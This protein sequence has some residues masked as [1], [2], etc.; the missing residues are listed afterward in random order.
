MVAGAAPSK[1][2][3]RGLAEIAPV[4]LGLI[5]RQTVDEE[6]DG[7]GVPIAC[8]RG[9]A[10][11]PVVV[12]GSGRDARP[13]GEVVRLLGDVGN[14][15]AVADHR[16]AEAQQLFHGI[17]ESSS[18]RPFELNA[19]RRAVRGPEPQT[20]GEVVRHRARQAYRVVLAV[21]GVGAA[22]DPVR[23]HLRLLDPA[24]EA[25]PSV[26]RDQGN[27]FVEWKMGNQPRFRGLPGRFEFFG[28]DGVDEG[29]GRRACCLDELPPF[30]APALCLCFGLGG[31]EILGD[32]VAVVLGR[33]LVAP[34]DLVGRDAPEERQHPVVVGLGNRIAAVVVA[35]GAADRH[36][37]HDP[38]RRIEDRVE[39]V[40]LG[41]R[42]V[43]RLVVPDAQS[44]IA[45]GD[46]RRGGGVVDLVAGELVGQKL[47]VRHVRVESVDHPVAVAPGRWLLA[48]P[49]VAVGLGVADEIEPV[50]APALAVVGRCQQAVDEAFP[51]VGTLVLLEGLDLLEGRWQPGQVVAR[52]PD[53][54]PAVGGRRRLEVGR[55]DPGEQ[56]VVDRVERPVRVR[57]RGD[58]GA[59]ERSDGPPCP[60]GIG[61]LELVAGRRYFRDVVLVAAEGRT[62]LDPLPDRLD[63]RVGEPS[64]GRHLQL[65]VVVPDRLEQQAQAGLGGGDRRSPF[66]PAQES[67]PGGEQQAVLGP[68]R[69]RVAHEA[70]L[71]QHRPHVVFE[72]LDA[73]RRGLRGL[74]A[75]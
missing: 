44:Q 75:G 13:H 67:S 8:E 1:V 43:R 50:P 59:H 10:P 63:V 49:L 41:E 20:D 64:C 70:V 74:G 51:R 37:E 23:A 5:G 27:L 22:G 21:E 35:A 60:V 42:G 69:V 30:G 9:V 14:D 32:E 71:L 72:Q 33:R 52:A 31:A 48:V 58:V 29:R 4:P 34:A 18:L 57:H 6:R 24:V 16:K 15:V 55:L 12:A 7:A 66:A 2:E 46:D 38:G 17:D 39:I 45:G 73:V 36:A 47:V 26:A 62:E 68:V 40:V 19:A 56:V 11:V 3:E 28:R 54:G 53:Q 61:D 65:L 25:A